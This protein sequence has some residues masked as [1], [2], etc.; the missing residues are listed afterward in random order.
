MITA[1]SD[2]SSRMAFKCKCLIFGW[3]KATPGRSSATMCNTRSN[4]TG[5]P[6]RLW[7]PWV[8]R[9]YFGSSTRPSSQGPS[10]PQ[11]QAMQP[12]TLLD[13]GCGNPTQSMSSS[14]SPSTLAPM[15]RPYSPGR[16]QSISLVYSIQTIRRS[17]AK[18][19][20]WNKNICWC[21]PQSRI[22]LGDINPMPNS[23][24]R[25]SIGRNSLH[26]LQYNS[27]THILHWLLSNC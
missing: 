21:Q 2:R 10:I 11:S 18:S 4:S 12:S 24:E 17:R 23:M 19:W 9:K 16:R 14:S 7:T 13:Y 1:S 8:E 3:V 5:R 27:M 20:D 6:A 15:W 25:S 22:S 26:K